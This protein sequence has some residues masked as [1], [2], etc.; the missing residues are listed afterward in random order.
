MVG[1]LS[2]SMC[3]LTMYSRNTLWAEGGTPVAVRV[4]DLAQQ[5]R[6]TVA[7]LRHEM[8]ELV[9]GVGRARG[10]AL[11]DQVAGEHRRG[12]IAT[13]SLRIEP[14]LFGKCGVD[15]DRAGLANRGRLQTR[16]ETLW[17]PGVRVLEGEDG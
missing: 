14:E 15:N 11:G 8:T 2:A 9:T 6:A 13:Q 5:Y 12:G 10:S 17:E 3:A 4:D 7:E 1:M 16:V